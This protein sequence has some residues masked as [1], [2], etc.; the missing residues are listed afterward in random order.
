M[1]EEI[2]GRWDVQDPDARRQ[3]GVHLRR[4]RRKLSGDLD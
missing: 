4:K 2:H 1:I 3:P